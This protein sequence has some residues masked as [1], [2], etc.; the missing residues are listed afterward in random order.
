MALVQWDGTLAVGVEALDAQHKYLFTIINSLH[1][2]SR[3]RTDKAALM[4][5][6]DSLDHYVRYHFRTEEELLSRHG[7][8]ELADHLKGHGVFAAKVEDLKAKARDSFDP[9]QLSEALVFLLDWLVGHIQRVDQR[10]AA[11]LKEAGEK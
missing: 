5:T 11:F 3:T 9:A 10:Y 7:Y 6:L 8:P 4:E 2:K 1:E